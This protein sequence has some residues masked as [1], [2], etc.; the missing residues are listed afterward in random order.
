MAMQMGSG[1]R[2]A[3]INVTPMIDVLLVLLI[4]FMVIGPVKSRGFDTRIPQPSTAESQ[5][6]AASRDI[7]I[8][9]AE[10]ASI[11]INS[12]AV[13]LEDLA[14][15][16]RPALRPGDIVFLQGARGL[17]FQVVAQVIDRAKEAGALAV[18]FIPWN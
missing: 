12:Q 4:I 1:K 11:E 5:P 7:V 15:K 6:R 13:S 9:V 8:R 14:A 3:E 18:A 16:L 10:N 17:E 2:A